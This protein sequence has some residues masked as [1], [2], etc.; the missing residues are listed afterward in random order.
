LW[1]CPPRL[2][3]FLLNPFAEIVDD[4]VCGYR[5]IRSIEL[6]D[7]ARMDDE[8]YNYYETGRFSKAMGTIGQKLLA[9]THAGQIHRTF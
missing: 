5:S 2:I 3:S 4:I 6:K 1:F 9:E 8:F 7:M